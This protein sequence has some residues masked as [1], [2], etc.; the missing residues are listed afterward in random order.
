[1]AGMILRFGEMTFDGGR[2]QL[3]R[4]GAP[5]HLSPKAFRLLEV[6]LEQRPNA[7]SKASI[8]D[9]V[10]PDVFVSEANL[11]IRVNELRRVLGDD[12]RR[13]RFIRTVYGFGYAFSGGA[14]RSA[15]GSRAPVSGIL[16]SLA[17]GRHEADLAEGENLLGRDPEAAAWIADPSVSRHHARITISGES[18]HL[19]DLRSKNGTWR[20]G[21]RVTDPVL[22]EDGDEIR[23]GK[24][25]LTFRTVS[26]G[27]TTASRSSRSGI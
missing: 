5:V 7:L 3:L 21:A 14:S 8:Q 22:L 4:G 24:L 9:T 6:L 17:W 16:H 15:A 10:W 12:P 11:A 13:P 19:E 25:T 26:S 23:L 18:A 20:N 27:A 2:R 1:M